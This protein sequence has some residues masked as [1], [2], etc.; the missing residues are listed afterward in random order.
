[1]LAI[2]ADFQDICACAALWA[3]SDA[4]RSRIR[5]WIR[6]SGWNIA[7]TDSAG[8]ATLE[9]DQIVRRRAEGKLRN[10]ESRLKAEPLGGARRYRT[11]PLGHPR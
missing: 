7:V 6:S 8:V 2:L 11:Y 10:L 3:F 9:G 1:M 4:L 5:S